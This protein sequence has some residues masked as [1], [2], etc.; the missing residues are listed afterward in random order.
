MVKI[1]DYKIDAKVFMAPMS[2]CTDLSF[3]LIA[4]EHGAKLCFYEMVDSNSLV[5][6][7]NKDADIL[8]TTKADSPIAGQLVGPDPAMMLKAAKV[9]IKNAKL[10]FLDINA[11]CPVKKIVKKKAGAYFLKDPANL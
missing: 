6:S 2:G 9:F 11:A 8:M 7:P 1:G 10:K 4:R 5:Y 3:R